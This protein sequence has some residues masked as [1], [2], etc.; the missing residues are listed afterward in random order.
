MQIDVV[1]SVAF[2]LQNYSNAILQ[3]KQKPVKIRDDDSITRLVFRSCNTF[4][5]DKNRGLVSGAQNIY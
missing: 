5:R 4:C 3:G 1:K 2:P